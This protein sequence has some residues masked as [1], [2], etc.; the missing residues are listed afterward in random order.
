MNTIEKFNNRLDAV[1]SIGI[2]T[3]DRTNLIFNI[4]LVK[5]CARPST[6]LD[7]FK[8]IDLL[9][10][11]NFINFIKNDP[12]L[13]IDTFITEHEREKIW[14]YNQQ[15][16]DLFKEK[17]IQQFDTYEIHKIRGIRLGFPCAGYFMEA[18]NTPSLIVSIFLD[19]KEFYG[20]VCPPTK[21]NS[22]EAVNIW[23][24]FNS[25]ANILGYTLTLKLQVGLL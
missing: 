11:S 3:I 7:S 5:F 20:Y 8:Y 13:V 19:N 17:D 2:P 4:I 21:T 14:I 25:Y 23:D 15:Y 10:T 16:S 9:L 6:L 1:I 24:K 22:Y 18:Y 12:D